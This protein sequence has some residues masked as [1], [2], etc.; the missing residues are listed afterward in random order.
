ME[1]VLLCLQLATEVRKELNHAYKDI[2]EIMG[3]D[4]QVSDEEGLPCSS[5]QEIPVCMC[6][7]MCQDYM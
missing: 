3:K 7:Y 4:L 6:V 2:S 1:S 5:E